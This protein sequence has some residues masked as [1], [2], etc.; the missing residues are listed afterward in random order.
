M[1]IKWITLKVLQYP[2][3]FIKRQTKECL[4]D[5]IWNAKILF[6]WGSKTECKIAT[7]R[8]YRIFNYKV[9]LQP[10]FGGRSQCAY[11][12]HF[13]IS[14]DAQCAD[15]TQYSLVSV[16]SA[17]RRQMASLVAWLLCW[18][19]LIVVQLCYDLELR[20]HILRFRNFLCVFF[21]IKVFLLLFL[22]GLI[23]TS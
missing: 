9:C 19:F 10:M 17:L 15:V 18:S 8:I 2:I 5:G 13:R 20:I 7:H 6:T 16:S 11:F 3:L 21:T 12:R 4:Q 22:K 23:S 14:A 1:H